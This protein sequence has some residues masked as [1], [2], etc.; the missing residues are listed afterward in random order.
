MAT[1]GKNFTVTD[2]GPLE[3][4]SER[5]FKGFKGKYFIGENLG[6]TGCEVSLN[7]VPA[8]KTAPF[9]HAHKQNEEVY[10]ILDGNGT[11]YVDGNEFSVQEGSVLRIAPAGER[12]WKAGDK[13]LCFI[14][15]Q[16]REGS[17][18]Q[19]TLRDGIRLQTRTSWM[20][21]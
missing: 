12:A 15:I 18:A 20:K 3:S 14:C 11:F 5:D 10:I 13:G 7:R 6:L 17:L 9:V 2:V 4:V 16:C 19:A 8:G 21:V 1:E